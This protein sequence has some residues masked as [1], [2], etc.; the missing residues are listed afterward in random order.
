MDHYRA[1]YIFAQEEQTVETILYD[2]KREYEYIVDER[3]EVKMQIDSYN[4][5]IAAL[6]QTMQAIMDRL[7]RDCNELKHLCTGFNFADEL[8]VMYNQLTL[9]A[10]KQRTI[11]AQNAMATS[12][13]VLQKMIDFHS[14]QSA[15]TR[16]A[17]LMRPDLDH[18]DTSEEEDSTS[19]DEANVQKKLARDSHRRGH[20][21]KHQRTPN[22]PSIPSQSQTQ[23]SKFC[24]KIT[25]SAAQM[26]K[27]EVMAKAS[28]L[29]CK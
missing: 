26:P 11:E 6:D 1:K 23:P 15:S 8:R 24:E 13:N 19:D 22:S 5:A 9:E 10:K 29:L 3:A 4:N 27:P 17:Q 12:L 7:D 20:Q 25:A 16:D 2:M 18:H 14:A 28:V 21:R